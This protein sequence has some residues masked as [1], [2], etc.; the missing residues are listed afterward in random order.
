MS[1]QVREF[2]GSIA[3]SGATIALR[4]EPSITTS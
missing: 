1:L 2:V 4:Q 3:K